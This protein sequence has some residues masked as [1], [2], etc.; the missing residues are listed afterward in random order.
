MKR[1]RLV[2]RALR[3]LGVAAAGFVLLSAAWVLAYGVVP[4]PVTALM[5]IRAVQGH[6]L[7]KDWV[8]VEAISP[9]LVRAVIAAEDS[10]F[11]QHSGFDWEA[12]R[13][14]VDEQ[15]AGGRMLGGS[16]ISMQT[17]K[18]AFLW[19]DRTYLRKAVE[20]WFTVLIEAAWPKRRIMEMYLNL[21]EWGPGVYGA[22]A[23]AR[24]WF[25]RPAADL[26]AR[27]A[28]LLAAALPNPLD[29]SPGR[30]SAYLSRR[31]GT[32]EQRMAI[33]RR[34]GLAACVDP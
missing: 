11:C 34:D 18:N 30:P 16:T 29:R 10:K 4:A 22:E 20:A 5:L 6:G 13:S 28:A 31:A 26:T 27:Q 15:L 8:A 9:H 23:A 2:R 7:D 1:A 21:A 19:P 25:G 12:L 17:A 33:V 32:I 3:F 14:A 24:H